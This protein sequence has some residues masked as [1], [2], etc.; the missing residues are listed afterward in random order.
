MK[1]PAQ[2]LGLSLSLLAPATVWSKEMSA[3]KPR[4]ISALLVSSLADN[5]PSEVR[6]TKGFSKV[7]G[8]SWTDSSGEHYAL[9]CSKQIE[10]KGTQSNYLQVDVYDSSVGKPFK[11]GRTIKDKFEKCEFDNETRFVDKSVTVADADGDSIEELTFVYTTG[12]RSDM[13]PDTMKL[14]VLEGK[15]KHI[16]RGQSKVRV[17]DTEF[18]GG[19]FKPEGFKK[20]PKLLAAAQAQWAAI[21]AAAN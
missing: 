11:L 13:S 3:A 8:V 1:K 2:L 12:C 17:S 4:P 7:A 19:D 5:M 14:V 15:D 18:A 16:L 10:G 21:I 9:F 20:A 6:L